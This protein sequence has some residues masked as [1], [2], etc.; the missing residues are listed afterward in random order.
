M[1]KYLICGVTILILLIVIGCGATAPTKERQTALS[2]I[3]KAKLANAQKYSPNELQKS[4]NFFKEGEDLI[5]EDNPGSP[6]NAEAKSVCD[7]TGA[8]DT[9]LATLAYS[10]LMGQDIF[11]SD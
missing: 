9:F 4:T 3:E 6:E 2:A 8:G 1:Y 10:I 7:V 11:K 5:N